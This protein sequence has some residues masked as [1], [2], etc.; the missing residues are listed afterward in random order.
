MPETTVPDETITLEET[1]PETTPENA[2]TE[3]TV[4]TVTEPEMT[5]PE[6]TV[7]INVLP[8]LPTTSIAIDGVAQT[9]AISSAKFSQAQIKNIDIKKALDAAEH[10]EAVLTKP[11]SQL[12]YEDVYSNA[13]IQYDLLGN[14]VK[15][16]IILQSYD[17]DIRGYQFTLNTGD[18]I[19]VLEEDGHID[20][21]DP[22]REN[23][24]MMMPAPFLQDSEMAHTNEIRVILSGTCSA[25][26]RE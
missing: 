15:E 6:E 7:P 12:M 20:L 13:D 19:P 23:I 3:S 2:T 1:D 26:M 11:V 5:I 17:S 4:P 21:Y 24:I 18:L 16:S 14:Q 22:S 10:P 8:S 25:V 9:F